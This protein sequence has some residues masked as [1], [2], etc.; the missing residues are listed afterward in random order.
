MTDFDRVEDPGLEE[1]TLQKQEVFSGN[2]LEVSINEVRDPEGR[3]GR[4]EVVHHPGGVVVVPSITEDGTDKLVLVKQYREPVAETVW[5]FPAGTL[6]EGETREG[7]ARRELI[8]ETRYRP[9][10]M[11]KKVDLYTSPGYSDEVLSLYLASGL[12]KVKDTEKVESPEDENLRVREFPRE[13]IITRAQNGE[14][15]D[16]KTL[17]GLFYLT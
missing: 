2:L 10:K 4:R 5:E 7:C 3:R 8:E 1:T 12:E 17:A 15:K 14:L 13:E 6:E 16:G 11:E 9:S